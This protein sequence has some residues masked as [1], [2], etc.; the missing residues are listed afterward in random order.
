MKLQRYV[1]K[2]VVGTKIVWIILNFCPVLSGV[3]VPAL[4]LIAREISKPQP[5][6]RFFDLRVLLDGMFEFRDRPIQVVS[7]QVSVSKI[8]VQ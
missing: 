6:M 5:V 1:P 7:S 3:L 2:I 8:D 4:V